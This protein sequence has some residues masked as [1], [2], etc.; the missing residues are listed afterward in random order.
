L[1]LSGIKWL[2][3]EED[4]ILRSLITC[5]LTNYYKGDEVKG[6]KIGGTC[7]IYG[8]VRNAYKVMVG[9]LEGR[10]PLGRPKGRWKCNIKI[11]LRVT[12]MVGRWRLNTSG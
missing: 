8:E 11:D 1:D 7:S 2:E 6:S 9:R 4:C 3:A 10:K 12:Q 5:I